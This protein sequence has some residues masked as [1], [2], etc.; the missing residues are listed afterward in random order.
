[1]LHLYLCYKYNV[2]TSAANIKIIRDLI[3]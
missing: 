2:H 1:M 3:G